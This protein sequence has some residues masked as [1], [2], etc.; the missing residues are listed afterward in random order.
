MSNMGLIVDVEARINKL[1]AGLK[2][3]NTVQKRSST[4]MERRADLSARRINASYAKSTAGISSSFKKLGPALLAGVSVAAIGTATSRIRSVV[5]EVAKIGDAAATAGVSVEQFQELSYV[6]D[7]SRIDVDAMTDSLKEL[8]LRADEFI[9]TGKGPAAEAFNRLGF[10]A[11]ELKRKLQDPP[12]LLEEIADRAKDLDSASRIRIFD[13]LLGGTGAE[14]LTRLLSGGG[15]QLRALRQEARD[16]GAVLDAAVI[17]KAEELDR[18][19]AALTSRVSNF[20]KA[21]AVNLADA[22]VK[23]VTLRTDLTDLTDT[24]NRAESLLGDGTTVELSTDQGALDEHKQAVAQ[25]VAE[26]HRLGESADQL[27]GPL[28]QAASNLAMLGEADA[29]IELNR[30]ATEMSELVGDLNDG[31][32]SAEEFENRVQDLTGAAQTALAEVAAIDGV[33]FTGVTSALAGFVTMMGTAIAR[34][35]ELRAVLPGASP[36]GQTEPV[37]SM[38]RGPS[39]RRGH[40]AATEGLATTTSP[41]PNLPSVDASFGSPAPVSGGGGSAGGGASRSSRQSDLEREIQSIAEETAALKLEAAALAEVTGAQLQNADAVE[42]ARTKAELLAAAQRSGVAMTPELIA[43]IDALANEYTKAGS[44]A[45]LAADK[46]KDIQDATA[47]GAQSITDVF[48][49]MATGALTAKEAM[50]QL[51]IEMIKMSLQKRMLEMAEGAG[52]SVFGGF[53]KLLGGGFAEGG[54]T[55]QGGKHEPAGVVH[56]GEYVMSKAATSA[57]GVPQLEALHRSAKR[58]YADGGLV[59]GAKAKG[60]NVTAPNSAAPAANGAVNINA[61][62]TVNGSAGTPEQNTDLAGKMAKEIESTMRG[63]VVKEIQNQMRV[64]NMLNRRK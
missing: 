61:P 6:S 47:A 62:I 22:S 40:R 46:I 28:F 51:I 54:F 30:V 3:A 39:S 12:K 50:G 17:R 16:T 4:Q 8:S 32:I 35:R 13:E 48:T 63:V 49:G 34:A 64:G 9:I 38:Q 43:Q 21:F 52:G 19:F 1:E 33:Q 58:G 5:G 14:K 18:R 26:Y 2:K 56:R 59:S 15:D 53:L 7:Q 23:L 41:R 42:L 20:G 36:D 45:E 55:G 31:S 57:I 11:V 25:I 24:I 44:A 60:G 29:S 37:A 27:T 10:S